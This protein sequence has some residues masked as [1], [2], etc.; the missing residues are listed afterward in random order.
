MRSYIVLTTS[1][2]SRWASGAAIVREIF[3]RRP[4]NVVREKPKEQR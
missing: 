2:I 4:G 1:S 3:C